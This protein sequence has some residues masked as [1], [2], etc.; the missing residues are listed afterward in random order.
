MHAGFVLSHSTPGR[1]SLSP[2]AD[3]TSDLATEPRAGS[4]PPQ[5]HDPGSW[6]Q[7]REIPQ[8]EIGS[9]PVRVSVFFSCPDTV[10]C[11]T[12]CSFSSLCLSTEGFPPL[13]LF[14]LSQFAITHIWPVSLSQW[15]PGSTTVSFPPGLLGFKGLWFQHFFVWEKREV[16][17][18]LL[19]C[20]VGPSSFQCLS[21]NWEN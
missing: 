2:T 15:V 14:Y 17:I 5:V 10:L 13:H 7:S 12:S 20:H 18:P 19:L 6:L 9:F 4:P 1:G 8:L 16:Q 11:F 3:C 21:F